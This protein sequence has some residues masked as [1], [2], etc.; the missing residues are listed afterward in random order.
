MAGPVVHL[1]YYSVVGPKLLGG[2]MLVARSDEAWRGSGYKVA[3][4][5]QRFS[6]QLKS[7]E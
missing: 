3:P 5:A 4:V 6:V 2:P 1:Q 7:P